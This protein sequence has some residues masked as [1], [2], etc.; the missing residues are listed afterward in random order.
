MAGAALAAH[1][2]AAFAAEYLGG[3]EVVDLLFGRAAMGDLVLCETFLHPVEQ[4]LVHNGGHTTGDH[5]VLVAVLPNVAPVL[6]D[7]EET[8]LD[9]WFPGAGAQAPF[10]QGGRDLFGRFAVGI[11]GENFLH[12]GSCLRVDVVEPVLFSNDVAQRHHAA[13]VLAFE[14][15]FPFAAGHLDGQLSRIIFGHANEQALDHD[16]LRAVRDRLHDR[17]K[18]DAALFKLAFVVDCIVTIAGK[19]VQLPDQD[20]IE[21]LFG[22]VLNHPLKFGAVV[23]LGGVGPVDVSAHDGDT[24][25]LGVIFAVP[26]LAFNGGFALAVRGV[27]GVDDGGHGGASFL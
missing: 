27:A 19:A 26:Q 13:V 15:V 23:G 12:N 7:L 17:D 16:A 25:A 24:V 21:N 14:S 3:Q 4:S 22:A 2:G 5:N 11:A 1:Q 20:R 10:V 9:K 18:V 8:V 6:E